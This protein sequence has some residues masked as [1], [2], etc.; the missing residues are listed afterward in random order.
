[1]EFESIFTCVNNES[2]KYFGINDHEDDYIFYC[3]INIA[4]VPENISE[5]EKEEIYNNPELAVKI[6]KVE[7]WLILGRTMFER[8]IDLYT[9]CDDISGDLEFVCSALM[10]DNGPIAMNDTMD[11]FYIDEIEINEEYYSYDLFDAVVE[12]LPDSIFTHYHIWT[13]ILIYY[14]KPLPYENKLEELEKRIAERAYSESMTRYFD[15][16]ESDEPH[17]IMS[18]DQFNIIAGRRRDGQSYPESAK[19]LAL[20]ERYEKCGFKEWKNTRVMYRF[21]D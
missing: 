8:D 9:E 14:P 2:V 18:K 16:N 5:K 15:G 13:E 19:N 7:G 17:L 20:W 12:E 4:G 1:M 21:V 3:N 11:M 6:G 10:E